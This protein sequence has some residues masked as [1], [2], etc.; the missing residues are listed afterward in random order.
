M[1][2]IRFIHCADLHLGSPFKGMTNIPKGLLKDIRES[3]YKAFETLTNIAMEEKVDFLLISGDVFDED[4]RSLT[5]QIRFRK[6]CQK[7]HAKGIEVFVQHGNHDHL[8]GDYF[9]VDYPPNVKIFETE[10]VT[11]K[12]FF[13]N[14]LHVASIHGFSYE[15]RSLYDNKALEFNKEFNE[16]FQIAMLHGS[17][18]TNTDHDVYA[19]FQKMDLLQQG[20]DYWA[21]GHIHKQ[22]ILNEDPPIVYPGNI[23]GRHRKEQGEKGAFLVELSKN[24][25]PVMNQIF[26]QDI[27]FETLE[28]NLN[29]YSTL[30]EWMDFF[31]KEKEE[32]KRDHGKMVISLKL[33]GDGQLEKRLKDPHARM[34][35]LDLL[36]DG[37]DQDDLWIWVDQFQMEFRQEWDREELAHH[38]HFIG[39]LIRMNNEEPPS[40]DLISPITKHSIGRKYIQEITDEDW[41]A[42]IREAEF[43]LLEALLE[44]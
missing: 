7:L 20:F 10:N 11:T 36:N 1:E 28:Y 26:V 33:I 30:E 8:S 13:K 29:Q 5:S 37:E 12:P 42:L 18:A 2:K 31:H 41:H 44:E 21:L 38:S 25:P 39:E 6:E 32:L 9:P 22:Q 15:R 34:E 43:E 14:N 24:H 27:L 17:L 35:F 19:P 16:A 3:T 23:Q 4:A 40:Q